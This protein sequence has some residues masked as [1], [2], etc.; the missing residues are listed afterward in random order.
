ME[1]VQ[2]V[3]D[4]AEG[5]E[6]IDLGLDIGLGFCGR[7]VRAAEVA[8]RASGAFDCATRDEAASSF[9]QDDGV[10]LAG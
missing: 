10:L 4:G 9:A 2:R 6:L 5:T 3:Y 1:H 8:R 7:K